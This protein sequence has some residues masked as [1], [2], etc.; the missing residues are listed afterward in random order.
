MNT[1][2]RSIVTTLWSASEPACLS[3]LPSGTRNSINPDGITTKAFPGIVKMAKNLQ[4]LL[5]MLKVVVRNVS[6]EKLPT[7]YA[8]LFLTWN[9]EQMGFS[10]VQG[11]RSG[12]T[13]TPQ[14]QVCAPLTVDTPVIIVDQVMPQ[15]LN[16]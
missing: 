11:R 12:Q 6:I 5:R 10:P 16:N 1:E 8:E 2:F 13:S 15:Q 4:L 7:K 14:A 9:P 3:D